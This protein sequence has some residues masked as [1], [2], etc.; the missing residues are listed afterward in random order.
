[1]TDINS[2]TLIGRIVRDV[3]G[4][5]FEYMTNGTARLN[6]S[7]AVN[8]SKKKVDQWEEWANFF[9]CTVWGKTAESVQ[10]QIAKGKQVAVSGRLHQDRWERDGQK[11]ARVVII[12]DSVRFFGSRDQANQQQYAQQPAYTD[13]VPFSF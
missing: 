13:D 10:K 1:M 6:F 2:V 7:V 4:K 5:D 9:D 11:N 12:A 8:E 3:A